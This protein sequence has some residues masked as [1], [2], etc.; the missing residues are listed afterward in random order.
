MMASRT[1]TLAPIA[2]PIATRSSD[3]AIA[4]C[5]V[6]NSGE[7]V[8]TSVM[9]VWMTLIGDG[10]LSAGRT[11]VELASCQS[12]RTSRGLTSL[13]QPRVQTRRRR[14]RTGIGVL[15]DWVEAVAGLRRS[16]ANRAGACRS[17]GPTRAFSL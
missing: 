1:P 17:T 10:I 12:S 4:P 13:G 9:V 7:R 14:R 15:A 16:P 11:A 5:K 6:P 8:R 3:V 2:N